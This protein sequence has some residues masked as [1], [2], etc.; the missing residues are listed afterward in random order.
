MTTTE[1]IA[2]LSLALSILFWLLSSKQASD[3]RKTL[4]EIRS[5][6]ISWQSE[7]NNATINIITSRPEVIAKE[8]AIAETKSMSE[9]SSNLAKLIEE[10]ALSKPEGD[11]EYQLKVLD[12][13]LDHHKSLILGKQQLINQ[14][15]ALQAGHSPISTETKHQKGNE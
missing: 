3:A 7:L 13:L 12:K 2:Y 14:A 1:P 6:V 9:F 4:D 15:I 11:T 10:S 5:A 8:T